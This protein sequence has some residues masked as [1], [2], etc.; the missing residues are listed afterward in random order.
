[1]TSACPRCGFSL[2]DLDP[3]FF[4]FATRQGQC[5]TCE[6]SGRIEEPKRRRRRFFRRRKAKFEPGTCP[7]CQ[8]ARLGPVP[9]AV[10]LQ[11]ER[12]HELVARSVASALLR[13]RKLRFE[14]DQRLVA[15]PI[16]GELERRL[17][18][19]SDVGLDYLSLDRSAAS[20]SGGEMQRLRLAAQLGTG[21]TG[22]LYVLDEPTIG[23]HPADTERLL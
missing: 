4:S 20:L 15:Q 10:R 21:L 8:G 12:Y 7:S 23:L 17:E 9:R 3:R 1:M 19:L 6:G 2:P 16:L 5:E 14:G 18:F 11:G 13:I 22:A